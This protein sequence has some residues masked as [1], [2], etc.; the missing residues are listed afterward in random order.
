MTTTE[1]DRNS[2]HAL[3]STARPQALRTVLSSDRRREL[4]RLVARAS[5]SGISKETLA[6]R[7]CETGDVRS[8]S[9]TDE[10]RRKML[11]SLHHR[12][13]PALIDVGLL[14][15]ADD[16][17]I[18]ATGHSLFDHLDILA[19]EPPD[20]FEAV[21]DA[22]AHSRR[23]SILAVL[24]RRNGSVSTRSLARAVTA[25][26]SG[27][28]VY[29]SSSDDVDDV[30]VSLVHVHLPI[31]SDADLIAYDPDSGRVRYEGHPALSAGSETILERDR[32]ITDDEFEIELLSR[33][34]D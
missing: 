31:L 27:F 13:L 9:V 34:A 11:A 32:S 23:R 26:E 6:A 7:L 1:P 30:Y 4:L 22:L 33:H 15:T 29:P 20:G 3:G 10:G 28:V 16:G 8:G 24:H 5:P 19:T 12:D 14:T 21:S 2:A 17:T 18:V 25:D